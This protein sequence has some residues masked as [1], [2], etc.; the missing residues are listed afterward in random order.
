MIESLIAQ[1]KRLNLDWGI[2]WLDAGQGRGKAEMTEAVRAGQGRADYNSPASRHREASFSW[3]ARVSGRQ[4]NE[5]APCLCYTLLAQ[6]ASQINWRSAFVILCKTKIAA[7]Q[8]G[9]LTI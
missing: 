5:L 1:E 7:K 8:S 2:L 9:D 4:P 3:E 6:G